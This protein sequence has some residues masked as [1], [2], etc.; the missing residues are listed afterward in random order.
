MILR[1]LFACNDPDNGIC[2][3]AFSMMELYASS[4]TGVE[5]LFEGP[6]TRCVIDMPHSRVGRLKVRVV[7]CKE[8]YGNWCWDAI[9]INESETCRVLNYLRGR[10][11]RCVAGP[12]EFFEAFNCGGEKP[13]H[14]SDV[15]SIYA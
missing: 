9:G 5:V 7:G 4:E 6:S 14:V 11:W 13:I 10:G 1:M 2:L 15:R 12:D 3:G 8:W